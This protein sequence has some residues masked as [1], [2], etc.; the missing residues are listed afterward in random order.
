MLLRITDG[1]TTITVNNDGGSPTS[2]FV[3]A[4][5]FPR[6]PGSADTVTESASVGFNGAVSTLRSNVNDIERMFHQASDRNAA[7]VY[8]EYRPTDSGDIYRS[9]LTSASRVV[10]SEDKSARQMHDTNTSGEF[11]MI[12]VRASYWEGPEA[13]LG[14]GTIKNG[15]TSPYNALTLTAPAGT[16]PT[17]L[18]VEIINA[19]GGSLSPIDYYLN[20]DAYVGMTGNQHLLTSSTTVSA[21]KIFE[22]PTAVLSKWAGRDAQIIVALASASPASFYMYAAGYTTIGSTFL[23]ILRGNEHYVNDRKLINLGSLPIPPG[24][25]ANI[26][27]GI[28]IG[29]YPTDTTTSISF[30]QI[31]PAENAVNLRQVGYNINNGGGVYEDGQQRR[32]YSVASSNKYEIV[33]RSGGP[34]LAY[35]DQTNRLHLL[36]D[37]G[38][39]FTASDSM[40]L[41]ATARPRR[42][43]I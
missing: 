15:T 23:E 2:P 37:E 11:A 20:V 16:M 10:W 3:G 18:N 1:S 43:T 33:S 4:V 26:D 39:T 31:A 24:A 19:T 28:G 30:V 6:D 7:D 38:T 5:Y 34:L 25:E 17:P 9:P 29:V 13:T 27:F 41:T 21:V 12:L 14:T 36:F 8:V 42:A 22:I 32:A 35:P 40:T